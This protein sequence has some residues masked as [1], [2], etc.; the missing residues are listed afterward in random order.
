MVEKQFPPQGYVPTRSSLTGI[1]V[2]MPAPII[3]NYEQQVAFACPNC[4]GVQAYN[5]SDGGLSCTSCGY[6][7]PP[8]GKRVGRGASTNEFITQESEQRKAERLKRQLG[9]SLATGA[10]VADDAQE[11]VSSA[12]DSAT[13]STA[14][15]ATLQA[16]ASS[17]PASPITQAPTSE[18]YDWGDGR[19]ELECNNCGATILLD[20][21][22]LTHVCPFCG[23]SSV[24]QHA[25]DHDKMRPRYLVPFTVESQPAMS[26]IKD[27]LGS[28]WMTPSDLQKRAGL[29][30]LT[31]IYLPYWTF[32]ATT[33]AT[34]K[35]EVGH[36]R[37]RR[38]SKGRTQTYTVWKW[39]S[40]SV[41]LPIRDLLVAGTAKLNQRLLDEVDQF[42]LGSLVEYEPSYLAGF[43]A[44]TYDIGLDTAWSSGR[45]I[46][47]DQTKSACYQQA[48][49]SKVR[50]FSMNLDYADEVWRYVLLPVYLTT[51]QYDG[52]AFSVMVNGQSGIIIGQRPI[53]WRKVG[54]A[55][56]A[57][58]VPS[59]LVALSALLFFEGETSQQVLIVA[60]AFA[61]VGALIAAWL[62]WSALNIRK[63]S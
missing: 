11:A 30:E 52:K 9:A 46:M 15:T 13:L 34:W 62:V 18:Q 41:R 50:N 7:Q 35:A 20:P 37:T 47:R 58:I 44:Q 23:S 43:N 33:S 38:D 40:G 4:G 51:Y 2:Y 39:E 57:S 16:Q 53:E 61:V 12:S 8:Q 49:T 14:E 48:S 29:D 56:G 45:E 59:I 10:G 25:F 5:V 55:L 21:K 42:N 1:E 27:W 26:N 32:T 24:V 19:N 22:S 54:L 17:M 60:G 36:T 28:S 6:Y 63:A 31:G 3:D